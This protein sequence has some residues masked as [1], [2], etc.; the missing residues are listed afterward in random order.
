VSIGR[1]RRKNETATT[2]SHSQQYAAASGRYKEIKAAIAKCIAADM[3]PFSV[4]ENAGFRN[5]AS[6]LLPRTHFTQILIPALYK[7]TK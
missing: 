7:K 2:S 1:T 5:L 3:R 6:L 4:A